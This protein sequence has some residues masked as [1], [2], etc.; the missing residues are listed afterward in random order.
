M[1]T[2]NDPGL[3]ARIDAITLYLPIFEQPER[4]GEWA[5]GQRDA[6]GVIHMPWFEYS[7]EALT[8]FR[9]CSA[10]GWVEVFDWQAW[11]GE[12]ERYVKEPARLEQASLTTVQK[13]LTLHIRN[14]RFMEGHFAAMAQSGHIAAI[15]RRLQAIRGSLP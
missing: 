3:A 7:R 12:A 1:V 10:N 6:Q 9:A 4:V 2:P 15:L 14:D 5:G 8:F 13:L 11:A